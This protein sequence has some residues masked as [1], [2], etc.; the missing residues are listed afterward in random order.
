[1]RPEYTFT[2][3]ELLVA[4]QT[5]GCNC[6]PSALAFALQKNLGDVRHT[7]PGFEEKRYTSPTMMK[8]ALAHFK[9]DIDVIRAPIRAD[10]FSQQMAL[11]RIQWC[12]PW[13]E[14]MRTRWASRWTHWIATWL[15]A[16]VEMVFDC[17]SGM[18]P[19]WD[20]EA[21]AAHEIM[22]TIQNCTGWDVANVWRLAKA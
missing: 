8:A 20:W 2:A 13:T 7:I 6:G 18:V 9:R 12:G 14:P 11:V 3:E 22:G 4:S 1:M 5:W 19:V 15:F 10:M 21:T 17:N 16:G